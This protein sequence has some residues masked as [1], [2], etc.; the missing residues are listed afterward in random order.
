MERYRVGCVQLSVRG[1][2][3]LLLP[4]ETPSS[5]QQRSISSLSTSTQEAALSVFCRRQRHLF[6]VDSGAD[7]SV[8]PASSAQRRSAAS[9]VLS[10]ANGM[11][12]KT[13]GRRS[14]SLSFRGLSV[15]HTFLL[16]EV[17]RPILGSDFFVPKTS[18][19]MSHIPVSSGRHRLRRPPLKFAC[20]C[21]EKLVVVLCRGRERDVDG[22]DPDRGLA[23]VVAVK[24]IGIGFGGRTQADGCGCLVGRLSQGSRFRLEVESV[25]FVSFG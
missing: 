25:E 19:S 22:R 6:L 21:A 11:S 3:N 18:S 13:F 5:A 24:Y 10:A 9:S 15:S 20:G 8:F 23:L 1:R 12:I 7:V 16:A 4:R 2:L 14:I 17:K